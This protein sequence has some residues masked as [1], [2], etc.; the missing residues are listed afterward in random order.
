E[1]E[2]EDQQVEALKKWFKENL[3]SLIFGLAAGMLALGG[4]NY[5]ID[6]R[7][8]HAQQASNLYMQ[9]VAQIAANGVDDKII[10]LNNKMNNDYADTPYA[11]L[12]SLVIASK[13]YD[14]GNTDDAIAQLEWAA[15]HAGSEEI[16]QLATL[17]L[18]R[19]LIEQK[20]YDEAMNYL[21]TEHAA[22]F[23]ATYEELKGDVYAAQGQLAQA[24]SAYDKAISIKG[25]G[26]RLL[27]LK[28]Q[29]LGSAEPPVAANS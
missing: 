8:S 25:N 13:E 9:A 29:N 22:A 1:Y 18:S 27:I 12:T 21:K 19:L 7:N 14:N 10:D 23:D 28:R 16:K 20:K 26:N 4:W 2:T 3:S 15:K 5:Y 17:R 6:Q 11:A 24:R